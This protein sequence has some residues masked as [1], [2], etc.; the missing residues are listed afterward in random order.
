MKSLQPT[1]AIVV[2]SGPNGLAAG[3][4]LARAGLSVTLLE[5]EDR[6]GGGVRSAELTLPGFTH[7]VCSAVYPLGVGSPCFS[8]LPLADHGL[9]WIHPPAPLAH[10]LDDG[11]AVLLERSL[12]ETGINLGRDSAAYQE[13]MRPLVDGWPQLGG[14]ILAPPHVPRHPLLLARFARHAVRSAESLANSRFT[15]QRTR[16]LLAGMAAHSFLP[17][18]RPASAAVGLV[19]GLLGHAV[20]W[21][22]PR[23][24]AGRI[25]GALE[26][27]F[28]SLGGRV[29]T[30]T[31]VR[32]L[33]QLPQTRAVL[34]DLTPRQLLRIAG[35]RLNGNYR[36]RL[37]RYRYGPGVYKIDWALSGPIPWKSVD[38]ARAGTVHIGGTLEEIAV[39]ER[40]IWRGGHPERP[41]V[42]LAQ[43]SLFDPSRAPDGMH[44]GW[45]YCHVPSGST[46]DMTEAIESQVE[47]FAPGFR[48]LILERCTRTA[49]EYQ[50]Y[51]PNFIGGD[52]NGGVQDLAQILG[53]PVLKP[54]PYATGLDGVYLCSSSTPPGGGVHGMCGYHAARSAL[55]NLKIES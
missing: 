35:D 10:P 38:C 18:D 53:R 16:A 3:I 44:T 42:L 39:A 8:S 47:R 2:G 22:V 30:G 1:D 12:V 11:S 29:E 34:L 32:S 9:E 14:E 55:R 52:I 46:V 49:A 25:S 15:C 40:E 48:D 31:P 36:K 17:L 43:Q 13:L 28:L 4:E 6:I 5:G 37:K 54:D 23:G 33:D 26:A 7:D 27:Y 21:P 50:L 41:F 20:G 24:G 19:L 45:A 51:N